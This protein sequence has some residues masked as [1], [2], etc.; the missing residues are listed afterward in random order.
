[1]MTS[2]EQRWGPTLTV[3]FLEGP[4]P[5]CAPGYWEF[6]QCPLEELNEWNKERRKDENSNSCK[7][8]QYPCKSENKRKKTCPN[9]ERLPK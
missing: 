7:P 2:Y 4:H 9:C 6:Q 1:M 3:E 8:T 5:T